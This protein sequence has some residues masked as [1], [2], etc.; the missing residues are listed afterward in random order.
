LVEFWLTW[1]DFVMQHIV[2]SRC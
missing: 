1:S 2:K